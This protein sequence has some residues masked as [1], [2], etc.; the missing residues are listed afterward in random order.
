M[1]QRLH[2]FEH[3]NHAAWAGATGI[4]LLVIS[5]RFEGRVTLQSWLFVWWFVLG[6]P[7]GSMALLM[8]HNLTGGDWGE[9]LRPALE[10][11]LRTLPLVLLAAVPL[12]LDLRDLYPWAR[13]ADVGASALLRAKS[14]YLNP[15]FF[16]L[17]SAICWI[18][19]MWLAQLLRKWSFARLHDGD[20]AAALRRRAISAVGLLVY[21]VTLT[22]AAV[23]WVMSLSPD[24]Y[25]T[26]FGLLAAV[27]EALTAFAAAIVCAT[28]WLR[29][30]PRGESPRNLPAT[31]NDLGNLLLMLVMTWA[32]LAFTQY[33][34]IWAENLP[35]EIV[36]YLPRLQTSWSTLAIAIV[37][38]HFALPFLVLLSWRAKRAP[39]ALGA[40]AA[41][42][43]LAH[44]MDAYWT[45]MPAFRKTGFEIELG[46]FAA[47]LALGG[48]WLAL[49]FRCAR[50]VSGETLKSGR[51]RYEG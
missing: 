3:A 20:D 34:I 46:D 18:A 12:L 29:G 51:L 27:G 6:I 33:L 47:L 44:L 9:F 14:W 30:A 1:T 22:V 41:L 7:L 8:V 16:L 42:L 24:W 23:D 37:V 31:F 19:W 26:T 48:C 5:A 45:V 25:S 2:A 28:W 39:Q 50:E 38:L 13:S 17:R 36:W 4:L 40:L 15:L 21:L 11:A 35:N 49:F 43:L 10:A 32:Y